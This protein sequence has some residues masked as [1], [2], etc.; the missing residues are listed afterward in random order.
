M[1]EG[2]DKWQSFKVAESLKL[3][4]VL[5]YSVRIQTG[6][7][8]QTIITRTYFYNVFRIMG[9]IIWYCLQ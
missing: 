4:V 6:F 1:N 7:F 5:K 3:C 2:F 9:V 8:C